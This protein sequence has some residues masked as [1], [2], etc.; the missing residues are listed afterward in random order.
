MAMRGWSPRRTY[1]PEIW[2]MAGSSVDRM[3]LT[4]VTF[5]EEFP[6]SI[7]GRTKISR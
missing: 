3:I 4:G 5:V 2:A 1:L 6:V 7:A